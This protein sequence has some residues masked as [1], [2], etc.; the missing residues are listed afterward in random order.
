[1]QNLGGKIVITVGIRDCEKA[2]N[3]DPPRAKS[4]SKFA[5]PHLVVETPSPRA[6][7]ERQPGMICIERKGWFVPA[8]WSSCGSSPTVVPSRRGES[9]LDAD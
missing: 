6:T 2:Y 7:M 8:S 3:I 1:M 9:L 5:P 4:A